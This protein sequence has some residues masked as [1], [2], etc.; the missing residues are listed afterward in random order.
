M[1]QKTGLIPAIHS[2]AR[3]QS[4]TA[5]L[6]ILV[7][8]GVNMGSVLRQ[9]SLTT[10]EDK[11]ILYG[12]NVASGNP[13]RIDD[14]KMPVT[15][16]NALPKK[17]A[18]FLEEGKIKYYLNKLFVARAVTVFF[19]CLLAF[20][21]FY[22]ARL[23]YGFL[24]ALFSLALYILDPNI[25]AHSQLVTT[26]LYLTAA[27][28]FAF[29][30]LWKFANTGGLRN[31]L[32]CLLALGVAQLTKYTAVILFPLFLGAMILYDAPVWGSAV[33]VRTTVKGAFLKYV[34]YAAYA[35]IVSM[36][37][38]N[39]GFLFD[40]IFTTFGDYRF[41]SDLFNGIQSGFPMLKNLPIPTAY[42]YL[43]GLDWMVNTERTGSLAGNVY[44]LGRISTLKGFP[45]YYFIA[46][47]LKVPV[48]TQVLYILAIATYFFRRNAMNHLHRDGIFLLVPV[49]FFAIY[50]NFF[51]NTQIGIRYYLPVF[52]LLY[53]FSGVVFE[54]WRE[55]TRIKWLM[56]AALY[57]Y[58]AASVVSYYPYHLSYMNEI[59]MD[60]RLGYKYL[61]DSNLNWG[62]SKNEL[63]KY[64]SEHPGALVNPNNIRPGHFVIDVNEL[65]GVTE[66]PGRFAW[67]RDNFDPVNTIAYSYVVFK[68]SQEQI[69]HVC[70]TTDYC[71]K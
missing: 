54:K 25:I 52:P 27:I 15:A 53:V 65:V 13:A 11:H 64:L 9:F 45:G 8:A 29:F 70:A 20:L 3:F 59:L 49:L 6:M 56:V 32:M 50:F 17:A 42:P 51:F 43:Q 71:K 24:P 48:S 57:I 1:M 68:I 47:L 46:S 60:R 34:K 39:F 16:L 19:S 61:A 10:D 5:V 18:L 14:S 7:F 31:G 30:W 62:Q 21:V 4:L 38:I 69:D 58:L 44:L 33:Q 22:W 63:R 28:A 12:E 40:R 41:R 67:L 66:D 26:D 55:F 36:V 35:I 23:L 2:S 37:M